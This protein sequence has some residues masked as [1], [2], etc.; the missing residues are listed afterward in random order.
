MRENAIHYIASKEPL[1]E[2][3]KPPCPHT[4]YQKHSLC[5]HVSAGNIDHDHSPAS[6][7]P[8]IMK[9]FEDELYLPIPKTPSQGW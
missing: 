7:W 3:I 8:M 9:Q 2:I 6:A 5:P 1:G 4:P